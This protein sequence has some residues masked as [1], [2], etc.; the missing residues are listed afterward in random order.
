MLSY[1]IDRAEAGGGGPGNQITPGYAPVLSN[2]D[3]YLEKR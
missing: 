3:S 2:Y 1:V